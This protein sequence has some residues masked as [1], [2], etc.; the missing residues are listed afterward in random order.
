MNTL[1]TYLA[2]D[3]CLALARGETLPDRTHGTALFADISG[4]TPLTEV[5]TQSLGA[6]RG[7]EVLTYYLNVI[8][9]A[10]LEV[11][12]QYRGSVIGFSGDAITC[13]FSETEGPGADGKDENPA[14]RGLAAALDMQAAMQ[15]CT[16]VSLP[17]GTTTVLQLK[18]ALA[19]G[20]ARRFV[21]G[22]PGIQLLDTLAGATL[23]RMAEGE[24]LAQSG[25]VLADQATLDKAKEDVQVGAFRPAPESGARFGVVET[26]SVRP[27]PEPFPAVADDF[28][29]RP[30]LLQAVYE[31]EQAGLGAFLTELRSATA[32]FLRFEGIDYD[33]DAGAGEKLDA[34]VRRAQEIIQ[35]SGGTLL[36]LTIGDKGSY[37]YAAFGA[38]VAHEN[39]AQRALNA[40]L[41]LRARLGE[42]P[43]IRTLQAG[44]SC[45]AMRTGA[46]GGATRRTYGVLGD[47]ANLAARLMQAAAPGQIL[48]SAAVQ[49]SS[50]AAFQWEILPPL[51]VKGKAQPIA[52]YS[53]AGLAPTHRPRLS[54]PVYTRP[55][56]GRRQEL[57]TA[58]EKLALALQGKGQIIAI[59]GEAG[60][61]KSRLAA[62]VIRLA[63][64][65]GFAGYGGECQSYGV[66]TPY[67][68]WHSI[69]RSF[70]DL[71]EKA[72][73]A[74]QIPALEA[75]L[76]RLEARLVQRLPLLGLAL[77][78]PLPDNELT[79][80]FD[81]RLRKESRQALLVDC[82]KARAQAAP[83]LF[84][85][86]D[87][88]WLDALSRDLLEALARA[89]ANLPVLILLAYRPAELER[90]GPLLLEELP[91]FTQI[92][93]C[94]LAPDES[95]QAI[96]SRLEQL[97]PA[98]M[99]PHLVAQLLAQTQ[100]NPF[101]LEEMLSYLH[102]RREALGVAEDANGATRELP[103]S[104]HALI[105]SRIDQLT[106]Q[107]KATLKVASVIGRL[108]RVAWL[109][110]YYPTL[111]APEQVK[112]NLESLER[113]NFTAQDVSEPELA[114][115]FKHIITQEVTYNSLP[116]ATRA[117][118]H[119]QLAH[120]L[121]SLVEGQ[122]LPSQQAAPLDLLAYHYG[123]SQNF[124]KQREYLQKAGEAAQA[125]YA[126]AAALDYYTRLLPLLSEPADQVNTR[127]KLGAV[128]EVVGRW[129]EAAGQYQAALALAAQTGD[130][131]HWCARVQE[132]LGIL[133]QK[134]GDYAAALDWLEQARTAWEALGK[135]AM[136]ANALASIGLV[137]LR[138][139]EYA[140][141]RRYLEKSLALAQ[142][143][144]APQIT[145][146]ALNS[147]GV[148]AWN[149]GDYA[150]ASAC[151]EESLVLKQQSGNRHGM[152]FALN[153]LGLV[154]FDRGEYANALAL[155]Q[156]SLA[157]FREL[158]DQYGIAMSLNNLGLVAIGSGDHAAARASFD[159]S[160][161]IKR[162]M[163]DKYGISTSL[164][165]LGFLALARHEYTPARGHFI[166]S[167]QAACEIGDKLLIAYNLSGLAS[168]ALP[169]N[170][171]SPPGA[172]CAE[173][174]ARLAAAAEVLF[175]AIK[176]AM[177]P[178]VRRQHDSTVV[179]ARA[180]LGAEAFAAAWSEGEA[181]LLE[182]T[183]AYALA[184]GDLA[185]L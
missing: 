155:H 19:S 82:A 153:N 109:H 27:R 137:Y 85:L 119:E 175:T 132:A 56:V 62:E 145:A 129:A 73:L 12:D 5:L 61:G 75:A 84:V 45:G 14:Y 166:E 95:E 159:E 18:V 104:L 147:L 13:W 152:A 151:Y 139:G 70:F 94:E 63:L 49:R 178:F 173:R 141:A 32:L 101:Y 38:P 59:T 167:L 43:Y 163:G 11:V 122:Q 105:L 22:D 47:E 117:Q 102:D 165:N 83:L 7:V 81:S 74:E 53:L 185:T 68:V 16:Q 57:A 28:E 118:L 143:T 160:L 24:H 76:V 172:A 149:Q 55:M 161:A 133:C 138:Q 134:R 140:E 135:P 15:A 124:P 20:V 92:A 50:P 46:Y 170:A 111:G 17:D 146:T 157:L 21:V 171:Q 2:Q 52:V 78:L 87:L 8:Y 6:R 33:A 154:A 30:W 112:A 60:L 4:F 67:L 106:E 29:A 158:G 148:V 69:W 31:R 91:N 51:A 110:G 42:L 144:G 72:L 123:H 80:S 174:A 3:R 128:L 107:E 179:A 113:L 1:Y 177:E 41:E 36:S 96:R 131:T 26:L 156:K 37:C 97:Y 58:A 181:M 77:D 66:N 40:A 136:Q 44:L 64:E 125:A 48:A 9:D 120:Y 90:S 39:D 115:L 34:F 183:V 79:S 142:Q 126:N 99:P 169:L 182:E 100:G 114:Y 127:L 180:A 89:I 86:E 184:Q 23:A 130:R 93:L 54:E 88:H 10:L 25:E 150:A 71:D 168:A 121:E 176:G 116:Y 65:G 162:E 164:N 103:E 108:F 35:R 98:G